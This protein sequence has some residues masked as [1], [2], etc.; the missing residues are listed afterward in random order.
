MDNT[1]YSTVQMYKN[2]ALGIAIVI[3]FGLF[4]VW[5]MIPIPPKQL[6]TPL[7]ITF[8]QVPGATHYI[9]ETRVAAV[10]PHFQGEWS[11]P[12]QMLVDKDG[13]KMVR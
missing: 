3:A 5:A 12:V 13:K 9:V 1:T 11:A 10:T 6:S 8:D 7:T 4:I 2:W